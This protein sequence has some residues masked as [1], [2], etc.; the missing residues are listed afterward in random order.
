M[1][2]L[3][4]TQ[5]ATQACTLSGNQTGDPLGLRPVLNPLSRPSQGTKF[6]LVLLFVNNCITF[7]TKA[8]NLRLPHVHVCIHAL[9]L[10]WVFVFSQQS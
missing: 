7:H 3:L 6:I 8:V 9:L 4:R 5:T 10:V 1:R 2:P